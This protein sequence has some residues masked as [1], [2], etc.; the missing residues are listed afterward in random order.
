ML[1]KVTVQVKSNT[2]CAAD[3]AV[4][5]LDVTDNMICASV[6]EG[7]HSKHYHLLDFR[8]GFIDLWNCFQCVNLLIDLMTL[9]RYQVAKILVRETLVVHSSKQ[10]RQS[11]S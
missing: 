4:N 2:D 9:Y 7:M 10:A 3:Y 6:T 5:G 8:T 11:A 1:N